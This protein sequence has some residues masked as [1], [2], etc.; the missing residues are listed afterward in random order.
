MPVAESISFRQK[1]IDKFIAALGEPETATVSSGTLYRWVLQ[2]GPYAMSMFIT[3]DSPEF[4]EMAHVLISDG[5]AHAGEPLVAVSVYTLDDADV[6][7]KRII[8]Q[9]KSYRTPA[10]PRE[11][12]GSS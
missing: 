7:L 4:P 1:V 10:P 3:I 11:P 9:W 6:L 8:D 5:V 12:G 2:R